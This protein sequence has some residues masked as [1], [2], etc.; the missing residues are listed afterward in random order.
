[1]ISL[2]LNIVDSNHEDVVDAIDTCMQQIHVTGS[3]I[4]S[5]HFVLGWRHLEADAVVE[6]FAA[7]ARL[8][9]LKG[10]HLDISD[11]FEE[12]TYSPESGESFLLELLELFGHTVIAQSHRLAHLWLHIQ[13]EP[14]EFH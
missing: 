1:M 11:G 5:A 4:S 10:I 7:V 3:I 6:L 8:P 13:M 14:K 2:D 12:G 9:R